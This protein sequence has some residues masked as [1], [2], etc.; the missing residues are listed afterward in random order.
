MGSMRDWI[1]ET[2]LRF[3]IDN[4]NKGDVGLPH[5]AATDDTAKVLLSI[6][7]GAVAAITIL[8]LVIAGFSMVTSEGDPEK[9]SRAKRAIIY[10]LL[11]LAIALSAEI[12]ILT[13]L[14]RL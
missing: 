4:P 2:A 8:V 5:V 7:F 13:V 6:L 11:G 3:M 14:N 1:T 9:I 10:A 12:I